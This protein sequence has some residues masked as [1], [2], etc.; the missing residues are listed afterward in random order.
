MTHDEARLLAM[1]WLVKGG[2]EIDAFDADGRHQHVFNPNMQP[3][4]FERMEEAELE[5]MAMA[6]WP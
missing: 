3:R 5:A 6:L 4:T 2:M 1:Q